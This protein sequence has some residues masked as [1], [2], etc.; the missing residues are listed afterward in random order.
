MAKK[1]FTFLGVAVYQPCTYEMGSFRSKERRFT[2]LAILDILQQQSGPWGQDDCL[3]VFATPKAKADNWDQTTME[4]KHGEKNIPYE[5]LEAALTS[6]R[7]KFTFSYRFELIESEHATETADQWKLFNQITK[8]IDDGDEVYFDISYGFRFLPLMASA[9]WTYLRTLRRNVK[10]GGVYYGNYEA[11]RKDVQSGKE[12]APIVDLTSMVKLGEWANAVT[13]FDRAG[14]LSMLEE[15]MR[16]TWKAVY[17]SP[18]IESGTVQLIRKIINELRYLVESLATCRM[19]AP[20]PLPSD[21]NADDKADGRKD[22]ST[23]ARVEKLAVF[24]EELNQ[25]AVPSDNELAPITS[26]FGKIGQLVEQLRTGD[27]LQHYW[28]AARWCVDHNRIQ[29]AYTFLLEGVVSKI[30]I[31]VFGEEKIGDDKT[32]MLVTTLIHLINQEKKDEIMSLPTKYPSNIWNPLYEY[33]MKLE[34]SI[35]G[36]LDALRNFRND[37]MHGGMN[38]QPADP[39]TLKSKI[40]SFLEQ[41]QPSYEYFK[42]PRSGSKSSV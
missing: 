14:D 3:I 30:C 28:S 21:K 6:G 26:L 27:R 19:A 40:K 38:N 29:Q 23:F 39:E 4:R 12:I 32:R 31:E 20:I 24:F 36:I 42:F 1:I 37:M 9:I 10:L 25:Y 18:S 22:K 5:T 35:V 17:R 41:L 16:E 11:R 2:C 34:K 13:L 33:V 7:E 8:W 15:L